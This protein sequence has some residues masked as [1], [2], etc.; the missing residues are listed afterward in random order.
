[1]SNTIV[2]VF[3]DFHFA[4]AWSKFWYRKSDDLQNQHMP[5]QGQR[6]GTPAAF[7]T[8]K[9]SD[10]VNL[11]KFHKPSLLLPFWM[12]TIILGGFLEHRLLKVSL[13]SAVAAMA[14]TAPHCRS[15][16]S[17]EIW[18]SKY[19]K[20][21]ENYWWWFQPLWKILKILVNGKDYPIYLW[22][23]KNVWNHQPV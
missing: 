23:I 10:V 3:L 5:S 16:L 17:I 1:M 22:K 15:K 14:M 7:E 19:A 21:A 4:F 12:V 6:Q 13:N 11:C 8:F 18:G 9:N 2:V 20:V